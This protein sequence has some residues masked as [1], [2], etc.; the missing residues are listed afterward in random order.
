MVET[1]ASKVGTATT[2]QLKQGMADTQRARRMPRD[3]RQHHRSHARVEE[4]ECVLL[5]KI[6]RAMPRLAP[7]HP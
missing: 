3:L 6:Q 7:R 1:Q 5:V 2:R 4:L